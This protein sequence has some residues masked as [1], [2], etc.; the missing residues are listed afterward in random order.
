MRKALAALI[1]ASCTLATGIVSAQDDS[2]S[3]ARQLIDGRQFQEAFVLLDP[4]EGTRAG[5]PDYDFLLGLAAIETGRFTRAIFALERVLAARPDDPRARAEIARAFFLAG[6]NENARREFDAVKAQKP[7]A[8]VA[9]TIDRFLDT[10]ALRGNRLP[11]DREGFTGF[12]EFGAGH[13]TNANAATSSSS[14]AVPL[15]PGAIFNLNAAGTA[16]KDEFVTLAGGITGRKFLSGT[17][18]LFGSGNFEQRLNQSQKNFDTGALGATGGIVYEKDADEFTLAAQGQKFDVDYRTFRNAVGGIAQW[19]RSFSAFDQGTA[20]VQRTRL[21]Y[22]GQRAR[23]ADRTV[24]GGAWTHAFDTDYTPVVF[25]SASVG[26][27]R[28][29]AAGVPQFGH[30]LWNVRVGGQI[31]LDRALRFAANLGY[32]ERRYGG[33]DPL[34]LVNRRDR[35]TSLRLS[36]PWEPARDWL[37]TPQIS[38]VDNRSNVVVSDYSR[39]QYFVTI[40]RDF[41]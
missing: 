29:R 20:F 34:F 24:L 32:E 21:T 26:E 37:V 25:A 6:E 36:L 19:R 14:F 27:E 18:T 35:E 41:R 4:M 15:F 28:E 33:P 13:D 40:R 39:T 38:F 8:E 12:L 2:L 7:P 23:D 3:R 11:T 5:N 22:P 9:A 30:S 17:T 16:Q 1:F 31:E 10:L